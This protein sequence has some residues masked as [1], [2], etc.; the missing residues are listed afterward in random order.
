[1]SP[2]GIMTHKKASYNPGFSKSLVDEPSP[3]FPK[4]GLYIKE[5]PISRAFSTYPSRSPAR[6]PSLQVPFT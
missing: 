5:M 1:M 4:R 2:Q 6:K 3:R